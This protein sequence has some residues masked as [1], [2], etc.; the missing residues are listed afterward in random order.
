MAKPDQTL[1]K[2]LTFRNSGRMQQAMQ[3]AMS[4]ARKK[5]RNAQAHAIVGALYC[6]SGRAEPGIKHL[7]MALK[8]DSGQLQARHD[9]VRAAHQA[10]QFRLAIRHLNELDNRF[11]GK[12]KY[13]SPMAMAYLELEDYPAAME[14]LRRLLEIEPDN[15]EAKI[16]MG[17]CYREG[18]EPEQAI[19][20][21]ER[22]REQDASRPD[23]WLGL[24]AM[25]E[26]SNRME[27][28]QT[29]LREGEASDISLPILDLLAVRIAYR[30]K[31]YDRA[32]DQITAIDHDA[33][34]D[35]G[36]RR[37]LN[38]RGMIHDRLGDQS[39]AW[40]D[41]VQCGAFTRQV[42]AGKSASSDSNWYLRLLEKKPALAAD[43]LVESADRESRRPDTPIFL[44]GFPRSGTTL[45]DQFI[46]GHDDIFSL[47]EKSLIDRAIH[48]QIDAGVEPDQLKR[49]RFIEHYWRSAAEFY[50]E[51]VDSLP[52]A[53]VHSP[54]LL[55][56][57][58]INMIFIRLMQ[59]VWPGAPMIVI[60]R[61]P[62][63]VCLSCL[64]QDF[65]VNELTRHFFDIDSTVGF[66][67]AAMEDFLASRD[68]CSSWLYEVQYEQLI[69]EPEHH[70]KSM[71]EWLGMS[72]QPSI[73]DH[74][75]TA[76]SRVIRTASYAQASQPIYT[77]AMY[78]WQRYAGQLEPQLQRL[79]P[80]IEKLGYSSEIPDTE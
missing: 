4:W 33:L 57:M 45:L 32:L 79:G 49:D 42:D 63:D 66:Y 39:S 22:A 44:A 31:A 75:S 11:P 47:E 58:P 43:Q 61:H 25:H 70:L 59:Q 77:D 1:K 24:V 62:M 9:L 71:F 36:K 5:P 72:W 56:R 46:G 34:N 41:F 28:A 38:L 20:W 21:Y 50:P 69:A 37:Y 74:V 51:G 78:R 12:S 3:L 29:L 54:R 23:A 19:A 35:D 27:Q 40:N 16:K 64:M 13:I 68:A 17:D 76:S 10:R 60:H 14:Q 73:L 8:L 55:D 7:K 65:K 67:L 53:T 30:E 6:Q 80:V 26:E 48:D 52:S 15:Y 2:I 18:S